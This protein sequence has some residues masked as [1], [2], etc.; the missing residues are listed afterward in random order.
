MYIAAHLVLGPELLELAHDAVGYARRA[1]RQEAVHHRPHDVHLVP[2]REVDEVCI[3]QD[4]VGRPELRVVLEEEGAHGLVDVAGLTTPPPRRSLRRRQ[5]FGGQFLLVGLDT[6]VLGGYDLLRH[7]EFARLLR[8][9][10]YYLLWRRWRMMRRSHPSRLFFGVL[11]ERKHVNKWDRS[12]EVGR[13]EE[14]REVLFQSLF[15]LRQ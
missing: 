2:Y 4:V 8:L 3:D 1:L 9:A 10:H 5:F 11:P 14:T 13:E 6:R 7:G 15:V 12:R